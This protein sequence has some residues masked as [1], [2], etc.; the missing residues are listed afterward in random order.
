MTE[1]NKRRTARKARHGR[2]RKK[3]SGDSNSPRLSVFRSDKHIYAQLIDDASG[4]SIATVS[5][6]S[7]DVREKVRD[8]KK[9][10]ASRIVGEAIATVAKEK[11]IT[12]VRFDRGGFL[13]HGRV[14]AVAEGARK[15]GLKF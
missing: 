7:K 13:Y 15:A 12:R 8:M 10:D 14:Q 5:T 1:A 11:G 3:I 4:Q 9:V 6:L 2:I